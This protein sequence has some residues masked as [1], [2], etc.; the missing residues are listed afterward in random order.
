MITEPE[1]LTIVI[2]DDDADDRE[3][4]MNALNEANIVHK[5]FEATDGFQLLQLLE[6]RGKNDL[7]EKEPDLVILDLNMP[8]IDGFKA[9][10]QIK[11]S[12]NLQDIPV[13]I[14]STSSDKF[15]IEKALNLGA[16]GYYRKSTAFKDI[17]SMVSEVCARHNKHTT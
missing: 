8:K 4:I 3:F 15:H 2:A 5:I 12:L 6:N 9:L 10:Q 17:V 11:K 14:L 16:A 1:Y 13:Y 7:N